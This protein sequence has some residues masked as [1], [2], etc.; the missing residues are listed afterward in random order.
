MTARP[1]VTSVSQATRLI[2]S[3]AKRASRTPS[4]MASANLSGCPLL[5]DSLVNKYLRPATRHLRDEHV[6]MRKNGKNEAE[7][8][9]RTVAGRQGESVCGTPALRRRQSLGYGCC[10]SP[11]PG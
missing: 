3:W 10:G 6:R 7:F 5:T 4:E 11:K 2:G 9:G 8:I 1:V